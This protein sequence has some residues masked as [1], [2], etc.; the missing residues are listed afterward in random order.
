MAGVARRGWETQGTP[1]GGGVLGWA[2]GFLDGLLGSWKG[3]WVLGWVFGFLDG[4]LG[5]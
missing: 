2:V 4:L 1:G 3:C 5:F